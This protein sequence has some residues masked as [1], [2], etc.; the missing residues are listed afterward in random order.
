MRAEQPLS[1][2]SSKEN[3]M[4]VTDF[5]PFVN[6]LL[7]VALF[8]V[9]AIGVPVTIYRNAKATKRSIAAHDKQLAQRK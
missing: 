7:I 5:I 4:N 3:L 2:T 6:I 8:L 1:T 9:F